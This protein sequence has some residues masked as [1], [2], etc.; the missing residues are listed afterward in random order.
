M[1]EGAMVGGGWGALAGGAIGLIG[2]IE[3][4][5]KADSYENLQRQ[6]LA[7][8]Q[9]AREKLMA[10]QEAAYGPMRQQLLQE[11]QNPTPLNYGQASG[12]INSQAIQSQNQLGGAMAKRGMTGS[13]AEAAGL[14][15]IEKNRVGELSSAF[16]NGLQARQ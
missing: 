14:Q 6:A 13:G 7:G 15:G 4:S 10:S 9:A 11:A 12:Q 1:G 16:Q 2:G 3:A 8:D 5:N